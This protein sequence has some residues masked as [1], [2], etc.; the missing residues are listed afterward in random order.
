MREPHAANEPRT[1]EHPPVSGEPMIACSGI[2]PASAA[3]Q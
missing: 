2:T 3:R 1:T